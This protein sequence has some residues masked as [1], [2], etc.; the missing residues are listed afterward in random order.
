MLSTNV[1]D[2][3]LRFVYFTVEICGAPTL[4]HRVFQ[5]FHRLLLELQTETGL[6]QYEI[7]YKNLEDAV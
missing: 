1:L 7:S 4:Y 5:D 3:I 6:L 2:H